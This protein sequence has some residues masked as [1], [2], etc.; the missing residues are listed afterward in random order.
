MCLPLAPPVALMILW[1]TGGV[2]GQTADWFNWKAKLAWIQATLRDRWY[3]F[4]LACAGF[5]VLSLVWAIRSK[6]VE[7]SRHLAA[8]A[9]FLAFVF[10]MLPRIV[11]GSAFA[12]MRLTPFMLAIALLAIRPRAGV[13][14]RQLAPIAIVALVFFGVR[15]GATA[16]SFALYHQRHQLALQTLDRIPRE[17]RLISF[18]GRNCRVPWYTNRMEHFPALALVRRYAFSNDQWNMAGAQ[19]LTIRKADAPKFVADPSQLVSHAK[20]PS[21]IWGSLEMSL[22]N[23]PRAAFDYVWI[24]DPPSRVPIP[25]D[26]RPVWS[27]G[28]DTLYRIERGPALEARPQ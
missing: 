10:A 20:C 9:L 5:L 18:V 6:R 19:L 8:T 12:D 2:S 22:A 3:M 25:T 17:A 27:N 16:W 15:I 1:R 26:L 24:I 7:F 14:F 23:F 13:S 21:E 11:F 28:K 4:D